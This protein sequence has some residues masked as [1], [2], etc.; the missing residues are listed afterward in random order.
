MSEHLD[1]GLRHLSLVLALRCLP[2][3]VGALF[4]PRLH[5]LARAG[6]ALAYAALA[7]YACAVGLF[8]SLLWLVIGALYYLSLCLFADRLSNGLADGRVSRAGAFVLIAFAVLVVPGV[9]VPGIAVVTFLAFG[10]EL[11]LR[12]FSYC[13]ETAYE[14]GPR[15]GLR[16]RLFFLL[17]DPTLLY[18]ARARRVN[19]APAVRGSLLRAGFGAGVLLF[20]I[21]ALRPVSS[22]VQMNAAQAGSG[23]LGALSW[24]LYGV[25]RF[26]TEYAAHSGAASVQIGL[27]RSAG[28]RIAERYDYPLLARSPAELWRRWNTYVRMWLE[29]YV[30][31]PAARRLRRRLPP[32]AAM[33]LATALT[34]LAS[35]LLHDLFVFAGWQRLSLSYTALFVASALVLL[36]FRSAAGM[37]TRALHALGWAAVLRSAVPAVASRAALASFVVAAAIAWGER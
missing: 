20:N 3:C 18:T 10:W 25:L 14:R 33:A 22:L 19:A 31:Y 13:V 4:A 28:Y 36:G 30:F 17:V 5:P 27:M 32:T 2:F 11:C 16:A 1:A 15:P 26:L 9:L 37:G 29:A 12:A 21:V 35:G 6:A 7:A 34:L 8:G 24:L 23:W